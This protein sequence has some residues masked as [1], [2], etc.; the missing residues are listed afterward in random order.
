MGTLKS[1]L[2]PIVAAIALAMAIFCSSGAMADEAKLDELVGQLRDA[3]PATAHRL[4]GEIQLEWSKSGSASA[5]FLL[6]RGQDAIERGDIDAAIGHFT[7]LVDHA[8]DFAEGWVSR[9]GAYYL[10]DL[11]GPAVL[12][13]ESALAINPQHYEAIFGLGAIF[14]AIEK[15]VEAYAAYSQVKA[16]HPHHPDVTEALQRL[17]PLAKGQEL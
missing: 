9:A 16:I 3:D 5:D 13:L 8:P 4:D 6:K 7:A 10:A 11:L 1:I 17:E 14:E 2:K 15:P 12:D